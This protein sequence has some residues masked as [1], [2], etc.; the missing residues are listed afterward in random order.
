MDTA[1]GGV[2][3]AEVSISL[4]L[5]VSSFGLSHYHLSVSLSESGSLSDFLTLSASRFLFL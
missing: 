2:W 5:A 3:R 1:L 4:R